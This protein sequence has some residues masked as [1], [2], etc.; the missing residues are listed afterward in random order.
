MSDKAPQILVVDDDPIIAAL[1]CEL[2]PDYG[3]SPVIAHSGEE[4]LARLRQGD[5]ELVIADK[6]L[7]GKSGL[8]ILR[9]VKAE[10]PD[11]DVIIMTA[12]ADMPSALEAIRAGVYDFLTK[13][14]ENLETIAKTILRACEK[15]RMLK[16][17]HRLIE[18]LTQAN[19]QIQTMNRGLEDQVARR[20]QQLEQANSLLEELTLTDDVTGAYNQRFLFARLDEEF[21]RAR[22]YKMSLSLIML[23][24]DYFKSVNDNHD[25]LFGSRVL[26]RMAEVMRHEIRSTDM[27]VRYGGD[28]F[29][30]ILPHTESKDALM[31]AERVRREVKSAD[32]GD[33]Q[34]P[35]FATVSVGVAS[36]GDCEADSPQ[37]LLR[38]ADK[39]LYL[40][41]HNGRN[42]VAVMRGTR[43]VAMVA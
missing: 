22:R 18:S 13:P 40:S 16:E 38:A 12:Y 31:I 29:V 20:T 8:D 26:K 15:R 11:L 1:F 3:Y 39:A 42:Q 6:N 10:R 32:F 37:S 41:K 30:V 33:P 36:L 23:D 35:F 25:H 7:P 24:V 14:F 9:E 2:L 5:F 27:L 43:P 4:A 28:E 17:N 19:E 34:D 21:R